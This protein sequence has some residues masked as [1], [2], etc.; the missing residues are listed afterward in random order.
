MVAIFLSGLP[1]WFSGEEPTSN[2]R[3]PGLIPG[4]GKSPGERSGNP[5]QYSCLG[6]PTE[7]RDGWATV[8]GVLR[9][10]HNLAIQQQQIFLSRL[11]KTNLISLKKV[12]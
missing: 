11:L 5:L 7:R 6:N 4:L 3:D 2:A 12:L 8:P 1:K 10:R 9:V